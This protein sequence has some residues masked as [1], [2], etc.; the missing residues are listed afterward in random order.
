MPELQVRKE[1]AKRFGEG[2]LALNEHTAFGLTAEPLPVFSKRIR[3]LRDFSRIIASANGFLGFDL[4]PL[5]KGFGVSVEAMAI[6]LE[7]LN[8]VNF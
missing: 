4:Q 6:R 8:L 2:P 7:E 3:E 5:S 1:F